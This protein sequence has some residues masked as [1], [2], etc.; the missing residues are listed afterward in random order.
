MTKF[1]FKVNQKVC[2]TRRGWGRIKE[3]KKDEKYPISVV[4]LN[5]EMHTYTL[6]GKNISTDLY[7]SL[8]TFNI[9]ERNTARRVLVEIKGEWVLKQL[10]TQTEKGVYCY[11]TMEDC[12]NDV[13]S[14]PHK[15]LTE[16]YPN[17]MWREIPSIPQNSMIEILKENGYTGRVEI[18]IKSETGNSCDTFDLDD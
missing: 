5:G 3:I 12:L 15:V 8:Y 6:D 16:F 2:D 11:P 13:Q 14:T 18:Y 7:S 9:I 17:D 10:L 4:F 1:K